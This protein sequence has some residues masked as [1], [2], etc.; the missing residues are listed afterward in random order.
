MVLVFLQVILLGPMFL[1][2]QKRWKRHMMKEIKKHPES[3]DAQEMFFT[4]AAFSRLS[5][6][7]GKKEFVHQGE[8]YDVINIKTV[9]GGT[10][11][12]CVKDTAELELVNRYIQSGKG[13]Q[14]PFQQLLKLSWLKIVMEPHEPV[15]WEGVALSLIHEEHRFHYLFSIQES[16]LK[17]LSPPPNFI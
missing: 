16:T 2:Q 14:N 5:W 3:I 13:K 1:L 4:D 11:I 6:H 10:V 8:Y 17:N 15:Q 7:E 12:K 9:R